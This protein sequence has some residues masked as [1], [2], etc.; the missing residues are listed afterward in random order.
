MSRAQFGLLASSILLALAGCGDRPGAWDSTPLKPSVVG[1][2]SGVAVFDPGAGRAV[3]VSAKGDLDVLRTSIPIHDNVVKT[4]VALDKKTL[5]V[6]SGGTNGKRA[7]ASQTPELCV[8]GQGTDGLSVARY[9]L[10][11]PLSQISLDPLG[12]YAAVYAGDGTSFVENPNEIVIVDLTQTDPAK[13]MTTRTI[14]SFGGRPQRITFT[15]SLSLPGGQRRLLVVESQQ[16]VT[17]LD[18]DH[19]HDQPVRPEITIP[20]T[21]GSTAQVK[22]PAGIVVDDGLPTKND[23][24]RIAIRLANDSNVVTLTLAAPSPDATPTPND[25]RIVPNKTDVGGVASGL[26]F[27]RTDGGLRIAALVPGKSSAVLIDPAS[28]VTTNVALPAGY[29]SISLITD[30]VGAPSSTGADV[31]LLYGATSQSGVAFW[32]LGKTSGQPYRSVEVVNVNGSVAN[33]LDVASPHQNL[34]VLQTSD[35]SGFYVLDLLARTA[36]PL[37]T[38]AQATLLTSP[39]GQRLWAYQ[40]GGNKLA[41]VTF[42]DLHVSPLPDLD[43]TIDSAFEVSRDDGG[44][45]LFAIDT[46]GNVGLTILDANAPDLDQ[47][48]TIGGILLEGL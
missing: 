9:P 7:K 23:D 46:R 29:G 12:R 3:F 13:A 45:A 20:L 48:R 34:K 5:F 44:R 31:A 2:E 15:Q 47:S 25:F 43:R 14:R 40:K 21:D 6:L 35:G 27:V 38:S 42:T 30:I 4:A 33:V 10:A 8:V 24:A 11:A 1:I 41:L 28:S 19:V 39:D 26:S 16:D 37:G 36:Q 18:L 32:A 22:N 17:V